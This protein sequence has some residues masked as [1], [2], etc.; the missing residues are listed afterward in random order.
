MVNA[1]GLVGTLH[2]R[3]E[4]FGDPEPTGNPFINDSYYESGSILVEAGN[5]SNVGGAFGQLGYDYS[6]TW[7][8]NITNCYSRAAGITVSK[9]GSGNLTMGGFAGIVYF[10]KLS[11]CYSIVPLTLRE[12]SEANVGGFIGQLDLRKYMTVQDSYAAAPVTAT[13]NVL[14][15][16][17]FIGSANSSATILRC[18]A[19]G[20]VSS[21]STGNSHTGGLAGSLDGVNI[22]ESWASGNVLAK[23]NPGWNGSIYAGGLAGYAQNGGIGNCYALG[24][25]LADNPTT[26]TSSNNVAAGGILGGFGV[27][28]GSVSNSFARGDVTAQSN[29]TP[30][31]YAGGINGFANGNIYFC[32][33]LNE[34]VIAKGASRSPARITGQAGASGL[35]NNYAQ[36]GMFLDYQTDYRYMTPQPV[37]LSAA[38]KVPASQHGADAT[39][40]TGGDLGT[41][42]FWTSTM[43]FGSEW[44]MSGISRGYPRLAN[45]P[46]QLF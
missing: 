31:A 37:L 14:R 7:G 45:A 13:G 25:V 2:G 20:S 10:S 17:G 4:N 12:A 30:T 27:G 33:A 32:V 41:S 39:P 22:N 9:T 29:G 3:T 11:G 38:D 16:G 35:G 5:T 19:T 18:Y 40:G 28:S 23:A 15:T 8:G 43:G 46:G 21:Y 34:T 26:S 6:Y 1:G 42:Y 44:D 24:D 36:N